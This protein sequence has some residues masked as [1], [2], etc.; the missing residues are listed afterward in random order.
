[1]PGDGRVAELARH[2]RAGVVARSLLQ[3]RRVDAGDDDSVEADRRDLDAGDGVALVERWDRDRHR[4]RGRAGRAVVVGPGSTDGGVEP[5]GDSTAVLVV[6]VVVV[7]WSWSWRCRPAS[8]A[9]RRRGHRAR[10]RGGPG[11]GRTRARFPRAGRRRIRTSTGRGRS[12]SARSRRRRSASPWVG[13]ARASGRGG[14]RRVRRDAWLAPRRSRP[15]G[16][17]TEPH[18]PISGGATD[19][20]GSVPGRWTAR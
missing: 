6:V 8:S 7:A 15:S 12:G 16:H 4:D 13:A 11:P 20:A 1:M 10:R 2:R 5:G 3:V 19:G 18:D 14:A 17:G 9:R